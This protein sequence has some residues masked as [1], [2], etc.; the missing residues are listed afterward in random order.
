MSGCPASGLD[1][2][3]LRKG[4]HLMYAQFMGLVILF[5][6]ADQMMRI[7]GMCPELEHSALISEM[8]ERQKLDDT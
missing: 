1:P 5:N 8:C 2:V 3:I 6:M 7:L 4:Q